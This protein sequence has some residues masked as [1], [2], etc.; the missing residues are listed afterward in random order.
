MPFEPVIVVCVGDDAALHGDELASDP[1]AVL[2]RVEPGAA[3]LAIKE[4]RVRG[5]VVVV[6]A[7]R[8]AGESLLTLGADEVIGPEEA[9]GPSLE[10]AI[11][12]ARAR[13]SAR[14]DLT[15]DVELGEVV[16]DGAGL[17][18][19]AGAMVR[20][21]TDVLAGTLGRCDRLEEL[22]LVTTEVAA[23]ASE[24]GTKAQPRSG[25][26]VE[27]GAMRVLV[28]EVAH[29]LRATAEV[30]QRLL[31]LTG[32]ATLGMCDLSNVVLEVTSL[33][34]WQLRRFAELTVEVQPSGCVIPVGRG[35]AMQMISSLLH[36]PMGNVERARRRGRIALRLNVEDE[37]VV[38]EVSDDGAAI[39]REVRRQVLESPSAVARIEPHGLGLIIAAAQIRRAGGEILLDS[40]S[41][42][43]TTVRVFFPASA[44]IV[45]ASPTSGS[46]S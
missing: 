15:S 41:D 45:R 42:L 1:G 23:D 30:S 26:V 36:N 13:A 31:A 38:L 19:L 6:V 25:H 11:R 4:G 43:G 33:I 40:E 21:I 10:A 32:P 35:T 18:L 7:T 46:D 28:A 14:L 29:E 2:I 37:L 5:A 16:H 24:G 3:A 34:K 27:R 12:R 22:S 8:D 20:R 17:A 39:D 9:T 44:T